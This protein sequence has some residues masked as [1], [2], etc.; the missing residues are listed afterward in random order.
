VKSKEKRPWQGY[1][2]GK[3]LK[4]EVINEEDNIDVHYTARS[5][6][7]GVIFSMRLMGLVK[8]K[9]ILSF[10]IVF[11]DDS[12]RYMICVI[13]SYF[14]DN[15]THWAIERGYNTEVKT[16]I[17]NSKD[18]TEYR[19]E[20]K[21]KSVKTFPSSDKIEKFISSEL[22]FIRERVF[23]GRTTKTFYNVEKK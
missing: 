12:D 8:F 5:L 20:I 23:N 7:N 10:N 4:S 18:E 21:I 2:R 6:F 11:T 15:L 13:D 9:I 19:L 1:I 14:R 3:M 17:K 22:R 16:T